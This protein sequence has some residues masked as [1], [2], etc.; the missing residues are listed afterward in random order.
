MRSRGRRALD[1]AAAAMRLAWATPPPPP[2][3]SP[4]EVARVEQLLNETAGI[5]RRLPHSFA[6]A[7]ALGY[8]QD[9]YH[10]STLAAGEQGSIIG[11]GG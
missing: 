9:L 11:G 4:A 2:I 10:W 1:A 6:R 5:I 8:V 3:T 7:K